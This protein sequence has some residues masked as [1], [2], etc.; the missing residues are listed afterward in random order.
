MPLLAT[1]ISV[2]PL[3][4]A[5]MAC[6]EWP[7]GVMVQHD[8]SGIRATSCEADLTFQQNYSLA[9]RELERKVLS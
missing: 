7:R 4:H 6:N 5:N 3:S 2:T 9:V 8:P 1:E